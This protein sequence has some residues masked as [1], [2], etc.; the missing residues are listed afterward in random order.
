MDAQALLS[1]MLCF[2]LVW[3]RYQDLGVVDIFECVEAV[4]VRLACILF[5]MCIC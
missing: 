4:R 3:Q 1:F 2:S 5:S